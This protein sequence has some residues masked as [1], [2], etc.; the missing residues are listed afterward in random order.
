[1]KNRP[2]RKDIEQHK[3]NAMER[4]CEAQTTAAWYC[5]ITSAKPPDTVQQLRYLHGS[6]ERLTDGLDLGTAGTVL[7]LPRGHAFS[8]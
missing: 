3:L 7:H 8:V 6:A 2:G 5:S 1:M 4:V